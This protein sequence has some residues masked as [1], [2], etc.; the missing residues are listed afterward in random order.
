LAGVSFSCSAIVA[1]PS[2]VYANL[3]DAVVLTVIF[4]GQFVLLSFY[5]ALLRIA[6]LRVVYR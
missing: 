3:L 1:A 5:L 6:G 4:F 2:L